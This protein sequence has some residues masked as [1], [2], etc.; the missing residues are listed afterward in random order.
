VKAT[1][2]LNLQPEGAEAKS[3]QVKQFLD[4]LDEFGI[5]LPEGE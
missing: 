3:Y 5:E 4:M 1:R 2:I